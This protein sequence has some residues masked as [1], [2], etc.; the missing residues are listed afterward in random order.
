MYL[1][2]RIACY[3]GVF[4]VVANMRTKSIQKQIKSI[5]VDKVGSKK[6]LESKPWLF[7]VELIVSSF[8]NLISKQ[9]RPECLCKHILVDNYYYPLLNNNLKGQITYLKR[10]ENYIILFFV[11]KWQKSFKHDI[12]ITK[13]KQK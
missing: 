7:L 9:V 4:L 1:Y 6:P 12:L 3:R 10:Q 5:D 2:T 13:E 11:I 8:L